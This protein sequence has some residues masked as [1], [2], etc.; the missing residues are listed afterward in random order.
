M[1][2]K[3]HD[4]RVLFIIPWHGQLLVGTTD[5]A[6]DKPELEPRASREEIDYLLEYLDHYLEQPVGRE[7]VLSCFAGLRPLVG[8]AGDRKTSR[9][10]RDYHLATAASGLITLAGGKWTTYRAMGEATVDKAEAVGHLKN[11]SSRTR[12]LKLFDQDETEVRE[13]II[14]TPD[15]VKAL[16]PNYPW[17]EA[18]VIH[19][20]RHQYAN[21]VEDILS[22]RLRA[23]PL[24]AKAARKMAPRVA[25]LMAG[26]LGHTGA[27]QTEQ[28]TAFYEL[29]AG[30]LP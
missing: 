10:S 28:V 30:Y 29:A 7:D 14:R 2:P 18:H 1:I 23:L 24:N 3:T 9:I 19:A 15:L 27:W 5:T 13:I 16:H 25:E 6:R 4:G 8:T 22:R 12:N 11:R 17:Q 26:E 21:R 20:V